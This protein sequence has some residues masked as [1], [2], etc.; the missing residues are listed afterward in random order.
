[1]RKFELS[2]YEAG[3]QLKPKKGSESSS[4]SGIDDFLEPEDNSW[5]I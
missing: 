4:E 3:L 2:E 1:M 5:N